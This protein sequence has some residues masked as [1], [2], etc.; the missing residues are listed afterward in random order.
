MHIKMYKK[1]ADMTDSM[2]FQICCNGL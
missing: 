2:R 1:M